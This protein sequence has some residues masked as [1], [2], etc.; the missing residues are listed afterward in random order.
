M[1]IYAEKMKKYCD[2]VLQRKVN[3][4]VYEYKAVQR[5]VNDLKRSKDAD[6]NFEYSQKDA[7][8]LCSFA[9]ALKPADL[10]GETITLLPW[11]VFCLSQLEGWRYKTE[12]NRKRFRTGYIEVNRKNG[13]T[14]GI[15]EPMTLFNFIKYPASESYL[16]SSRDDLADKTFKEIS[17]IIEADE[18]LRSGCE[19]RSL[20]ITYENSRIG[21]FCDGGKSADG[22]RPRFACIDEFHEY[23]TDQML[24]S[25]MYGMRSKKDAQ[26]VIITTADADI[27][28][29][30]YEQNIKSKRILNN[31][32][33]QEDFFC[34]IYAID[35][36]DDFHDPSV[37]R[38]ANPSLYAIIE[39]DVIQSDIQDAELTPA[40]IPELKAKTFGIWGGGG[41]KSWIPLEIFQKNKD[42]KIEIEDFENCPCCAALDLSN[43]DD[44]T[45]YTKMFLKDGIIYAFHKFY[46]PEEQLAN[47][48][49]RENVNIYSWVDSGAIVATPGATVDYSFMIADIVEDTNKYQFMA[50]GYDKWQAHDVINGIEAERPEILL[51]EIEQS[52]KKLSPMTQA[53]EK[54][55]RDGKLVDNSDVMA[56]M[57]NN[58]E[59]RP[60]ANGNY[61]PMK[62]SKTST[63]RIDGV[64]TSI[65]AHSLLFNPEVNTPPTTMT[66]EELKALF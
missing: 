35:E 44:F 46:V 52:L 20:A 42:V 1:S 3:A 22:F 53:Y 10:N 54:T 29:P 7:D 37:W 66:F 39:P 21:F 5:F 17:A 12:P 18:N 9:E 57:I 63:R 55:I 47:K 2:E 31:L 50:I 36:G 11:Q 14:S 64:I 58:A 27:N 41:R 60:D 49:K 56:W 45:A 6:F 40:R 15:L 32:Q 59:I 34:I 61:K 8:I 28:R 16:V 38:K 13:K 65:M 62:P 51:I 33:T 24:T 4:G 30:C 23:A 48:Y 43:V 19:C 26:L 25:M